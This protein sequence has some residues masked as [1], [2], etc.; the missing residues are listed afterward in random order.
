MTRLALCATGVAL[1]CLIVVGRLV[2]VQVLDH[3]DYVE[4][5][6]RQQ[7]RVHDLD[8]PRGTIFDARG[9]ILA[10]SVEVPS[11]AVDPRKVA[12]PAAIASLLVDGLGV[13]YDETVATLEQEGRAFAWIQ[14]KGDPRAVEALQA[15]VDKLETKERFFYQ[16]PEHK[17]IYPF[18]PLAAHVLG[19]VG[20]D[21]EGLHGLEARYEA[22]V[23]SRK[24]QRLVLRD[25]RAGQ[26][27][28]ETAAPRPGRDLHLTIDA[29]IQHFA[30]QALANGLERSGADRGSVVVLD[31]HDGAVLAMASAPSF[32]P[33]RP[34]AVDPT[35]WRNQAISEAFEPGSTFKMITLASALETGA[36]G[37]ATV[38]DCGMGGIRLGGIR[39]NDHKP[40]GALTVRQVI[41]KS[42]NVGAIKLGQAA[43]RDRFHATVTGFGFGALTGIDLPGESRGLLRRPSS[44]Q[45]IT[46]AYLS[47]GQGLSVTPLQL[48]VAY[49]AVANDGWLVTPRVV[50][51]IDGKKVPVAERRML[52]L[53]PSTLATVRDILSTVIAEGATGRKAAVD[54]YRVAGKT[55]TAEKALPGRGYV[56]GHYIAGFTGFV[57][58]DS[59]RLVIVVS[60]DEPWPLYNGGDAAA[61]VF[62]EIAS[63]SLLYL[64]VSPAD[65]PREHWPAE[66]PDSHATSRAKSQLAARDIEPMRPEVTTE[67]GVV[68][69]LTGLTA[70]EAV[71]VT[72]R[73]GQ[74]PVLH[75]SGFIA[76]QEPAPGSAYEGPIRVWLRPEGG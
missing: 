21:N 36:V 60:I 43:G 12:D 42:S 41:A 76:R 45:P 66:D 61:P 9:R 24:G 51:R 29:T 37:E 7:Q 38:F 32:D 16:V 3:D 69:D 54:G 62:A 39:I 18:G 55:G 1:W 23:A 27:H 59:P 19:F 8:A 67:P 52:K 72:S 71:V 20:T 28:L 58:L 17:R 34:L 35:M 26:L 49:A 13:E 46:P 11:V 48:A 44:W 6:T 47:F 5:A 56:A 70:R 2:W 68:P 57:P 4:R 40:F 50:D 25:G 73:F 31:P 15:R 74:Y 53:A 33:N 10:V 65:G 63:R 14:R 22:T 75:G 30:E 64:G